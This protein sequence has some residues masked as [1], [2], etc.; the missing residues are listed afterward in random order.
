MVR[1]I[2]RSAKR[3]DTPCNEKND[4]LS[5]VQHEI[6]RLNSIGCMPTVILAPPSMLKS[7]V[8]F[9]KEG[10]G[11]VEFTRERGSAATLEIMGLGRLRIYL[12]GGGRL[13][14]NMVILNGADIQWNMLVDPDTHY[15]VTM[16]IGIGDYPD[17]ATFI[18]G[19]TI[20]CVVQVQEGISIIPIER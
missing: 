18:V 13:Q 3:I 15:A 12:F 1:V 7:F 10:R 8:H 14:N 17:K 11:K 5:I 20:K 2:Q 9:F 16:G 4:G 19:T 6:E